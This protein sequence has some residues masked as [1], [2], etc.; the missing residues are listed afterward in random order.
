MSLN[1]EFFKRLG[2]LYEVDLR[3]SAQHLLNILEKKHCQ[4]PKVIVNKITRIKEDTYSIAPWVE[5]RK[6]K[7]IVAHEL[8]KI[9]PTF[10]LFLISDSFVKSK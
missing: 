1:C 8:Y 10:I 9:K 6:N 2:G 4:Y 7:K 5:R 3:Y